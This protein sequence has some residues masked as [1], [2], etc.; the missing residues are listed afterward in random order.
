MNLPT[1][2]DIRRMRI[3]AGLTQRELAER[4]GVSQS[5]IARIEAGTVDPRLSTLRKILKA[6]TPSIGE[7]KAG[8]VMHKPVI[9][10]DVDEPVKSVVELM[11]KYGISQVP[12]LEKGVVV[13]TI[14]ETTLLKH[15]LKTKNPST[16]FNKPAR[17]VMDDPL[18][19]VSPSSSI[20]DVLAL[21]SGENP[22]VLVMEGG[23]LVGIITKIDVISAIKPRS[24][25][26]HESD[27]GQA[28]QVPQY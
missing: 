27:E 23:K 6:L 17:E 7:L 12:V 4:A 19:I 9:W 1:P 10:V 28:Q 5:L 11:E 16:L 22:A 20:S 13:G 18:P 21:L 2:E 24:R 8:H 14:H 15:F 3:M 26:A 25:G